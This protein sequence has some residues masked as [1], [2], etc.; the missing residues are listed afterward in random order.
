MRG[1]P[2]TV[3]LLSLANAWLFIGNS[4]LVTVSALIGFE[5]A[6]DKRLATLPLALQ[7]FTIMCGSVPAS[8]F[9]GRF[10]RKA[11]FL[12]AAVL[13]LVG[14]ALAL[15]AI[16]GERFAMYCAAT[17]CFGLFA[18]FGNYYRFTAAEVVAPDARAKAISLVMAGG[19]IAAFIGPNLASWSGSMFETRLYAGAFV[20][21]AGVYLASI[22]T[23]AA[24]TLPPPLPR[25]SATGGR[26]LGQIARQ[27]LFLVAVAC[28][29]LGYGTMN[30][31]MTST[32]LELAAQTWGLAAT[33]FV[34]QWHVV[35]MFAPSFVTGHLIDR[36]G[37][38]AVLGAGV[39]LGLVAL[40]V[41]LA[42][43]SIAHFA[44]GLVL[45]GIAWNFLFVGGTTLLTGTYRPEERS[46]AQACNDLLVFGTVTITALSAGTLHYTLGWRAVN[47]AALPLLGTAALAVGW[48]ALRR[49][50][51]PGA[52]PASPAVPAGPATPTTSAALTPG[53]V[54]PTASRSANP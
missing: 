47:L 14:T 24:A 38:A 22:A 27:P 40:G 5:L 15:G 54:L 52:G 35:A 7:F 26:P 10:G 25:G 31:V 13:G 43:S 4:L 36:F 33:A 6:T 45:L 12:L 39:T 32:P 11:G 17:V 23:V 34:I 53:P 19:V 29:M 48:L 51:V 16:F 37:I 3:W 21:L 28:Q 20:I 41:N 46:R 2:R 44:V 42:A 1:L 50:A 30:L 49:D 18:A 8:L 9:M